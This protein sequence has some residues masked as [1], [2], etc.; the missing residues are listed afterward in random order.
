MNKDKEIQD[1]LDEL[2]AERVLARNLDIW[3]DKA[4]HSLVEV[5][6]KHHEGH[7]DKFCPKNLYK[8]LSVFIANIYD[9]AIIPEPEPSD[10]IS[11]R[12]RMGEKW[13]TLWLG[14]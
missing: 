12:A 6:N 3:R 4:T 2:Y 9:Q 11:F 8:R 14:E 13:K 5:L 10:N 7:N 1:A